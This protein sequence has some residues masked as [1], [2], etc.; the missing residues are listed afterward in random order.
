MELKY[1]SHCR[2]VDVAE[3]YVKRRFWLRLASVPS[4]GLTSLKQRLSSESFI[5]KQRPARKYSETI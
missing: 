4:V 1:G 5:L 2:S 3:R